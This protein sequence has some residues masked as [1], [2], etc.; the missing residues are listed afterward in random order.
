V[1]ICEK[2][3]IDGASLA[4][5]E[6]SFSRLQELVPPVYVLHL[7]C[8]NGESSEK[9]RVY[10]SAM[11]E[12]LDA[13]IVSPNDDAIFDANA[14]ITFTGSVQ[15]GT[16]PYTYQW[17]SDVDGLLS[18]SIGFATSSLTTRRLTDTDSDEIIPHTIAFAVTDS[19]GFESKEF[20]QVTIKEGQCDFNDD[21]VTDFL[22][23][24]SLF[25]AWLD[26]IGEGLYDDRLDLNNDWIIDL[27]DLAHCAGEWRP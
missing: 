17:S 1:P 15:G 22:D 18:T 11:N 13:N 5:Y 19:K 6:D 9:I 3:H 23:I 24:A 8:D 2:I 7:T 12:P 25:D 14:T 21:G 16:P 10:I 26:E 27:Q 20:I 4:Y